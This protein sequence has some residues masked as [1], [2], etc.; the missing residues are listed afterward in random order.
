MGYV[1]NVI[2]LQLTQSLRNHELGASCRHSLIQSVFYSNRRKRPS[3]KT[4]TVRN[5]F[6]EF[7]MTIDPFY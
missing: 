3:E 2:A 4:F 6:F 5:L 7:F 1:S